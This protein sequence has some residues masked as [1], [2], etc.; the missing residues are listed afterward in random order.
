LRGLKIP[1]WIHIRQL[2][3]ISFFFDE[4]DFLIRIG[5]EKGAATICA[6]LMLSRQ[7]SLHAS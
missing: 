3:A 1:Y 4:T 5:L 6:Y 7:S 2:F